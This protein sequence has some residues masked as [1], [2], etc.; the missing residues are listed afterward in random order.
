MMYCKDCKWE[1]D[2]QAGD[3]IP[4]TCKKCGGD[5]FLMQLEDTDS[6]LRQYFNQTKRNVE[7]VE[8]VCPICITGWNTKTDKLRLEFIGWNDLIEHEGCP[9]CLSECERCGMVK[10]HQGNLEHCL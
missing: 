6:E 8:Y 3:P 5:N 4:A 10:D 2:T 9:D 1:F 7:L